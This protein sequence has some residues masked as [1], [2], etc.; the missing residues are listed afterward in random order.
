MYNKKW[1]KYID[2][3]KTLKIKKEK[4]IGCGECTNVCPHGVWYIENNIAQIGES[5]Y[6]MECGACKINCIKGAILVD[7]G[8][9]CAGLIIINWLKGKK[10]LEWNG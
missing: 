6:C 4:C 5:E 1:M 7:S 8:T 9:G 3:G 2:N 10:K